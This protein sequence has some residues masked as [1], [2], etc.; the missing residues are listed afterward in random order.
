MGKKFRV[1]WTSVSKSD[2]RR[3][4]EYISLDN[5][6]RAMEVYQKIRVEAEGLQQ[7]PSRGRIVPE[8]RFNGVLLYRELIV[9]S[10]RIIYRIDGLN[11]W[12]L[13]VIDS[14]RDVPNLLLER[15]IG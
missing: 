10:W 11:V 2:L 12:V 15:F 6:T 9:A 14:R 3:I 1:A 13:A 4:M 5:P 8:L 7:F